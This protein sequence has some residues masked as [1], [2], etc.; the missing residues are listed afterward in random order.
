MLAKPCTGARRREL[1]TGHPSRPTI[2][3][4]VPPRCSRRRGRTVAPD[5]LAHSTRNGR[6]PVDGS[7]DHATDRTLRLPLRDTRS[8]AT[9]G[10]VPASKECRVHGRTGTGRRTLLRCLRL[11]L[12]IS[13]YT[14]AT[15]QSH[16]TE[17]KKLKSTDQI[18]LF[19]NLNGVPS[20]GQSAD[21]R[22]CFYQ[23]AAGEWVS[24]AG[25]YLQDIDNECVTIR[26][27]LAEKIFGSLSNYNV[28][29][30]TTPFFLAQ[31]GLNSECSMSR[32]QFEQELTKLPLASKQSINRL[33]YF[34]DCEKLIS[35]I[36]EGSKE[37]S[38]ILGEFYRVLNLEPLF[39]PENVVPD[40]IRF[41]SSPTTSNLFALLNFIYIRLHS[42]LDYSVKLA[43]EVENLKMECSRYP[44]LASC[45]KTFGDRKSININET[46]GTL[47][48]SV[49]IIREVELTRNQI[50][51]DGFLGELP[52]V[53]QEKQDGKVVERFILVPDR[54][55]LVG[56][57]SVIEIYFT[58]ESTK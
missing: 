23:N 21:A 12:A 3:A 10:C 36:Q 14:I 5:R 34:C 50:I 38:H 7:G 57:N 15:R 26:D 28:I 13:G 44:R 43:F 17:A 35:G 30:R 55:E 42:L 4:R 54:N 25:Q 45:G 20:R 6:R 24:E 8:G 19:L 9:G 49:A 37:I 1:P 29:V 2:G 39:F 48:E 56:R 33:L 11:I 27:A 32:D 58:A 16:G 40:G 47:F 52:K 31:A 51:H 46:Q 41:C 22:I 18:P 53:Y